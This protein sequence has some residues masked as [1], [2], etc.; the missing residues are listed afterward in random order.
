MSL[1][2]ER[3]VTV[4]LGWQDSSV[5]NTFVTRYASATAST[6]CTVKQFLAG[7]Y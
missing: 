1:S 3:G 2:A 5:C 7:K 4:T 6:Q